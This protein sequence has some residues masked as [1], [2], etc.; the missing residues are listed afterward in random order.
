MQQDGNNCKRIM[1]TR[2]DLYSAY[3]KMKKPCQ[4][5]CQPWYDFLRKDGKYYGPSVGDGEEEPDGTYA[6]NVTQHCSVSHAFF[7]KVCR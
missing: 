5:E 1:D 7:P 2:K 6:I 3:F 4:D